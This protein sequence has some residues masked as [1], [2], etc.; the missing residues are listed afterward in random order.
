MKKAKPRLKKKN[1][2][3]KSF[4]IVAIGASAGGL[5]AISELLENLSPETGMAF[6]YIQ[7]LDPT[8]K[9]MLSTI[10][11]RFTKMKVLEA[12]H[13]MVLERNHVYIIP[14]NK[15]MAVS[16]GMLTLDARQAKPAAHMPID[17]FFA[18][19]AENRKEEAIGIVLSGNASDG[20]LGLNAIKKAGGLTFAQDETAKFQSMPRSA[21]AEGVIDLVLSPKEIGDELTRISQHTDAI[22]KI[23]KDATDDTALDKDLQTIIQLLKESTGVDFRHYKKNT[24]RRRVVRRM[25]LHKLRVLK[26]YV[27]YLK[28]NPQEIKV[29]YQDLLINI[30]SFFRDP[31]TLEYLRKSLL[32]K[33]I[34]GKVPDEPVRIWVAAC[35]TGEEAYSLAII[36]M[37]IMEDRLPVIP[38]QIFATDLSQQAIAK[39]RLGTYSKGDVEGISPDRLKRF[40]LKTENGYRIAKAI[41]D[42]CVFAPHNVLK[43]PPFSRL[44]LI[45]C[46]NLM[47]YLNTALQK[48]ILATFHY[49]LNPGGYLVLGKSETIGTSAQLFSAVE[50]KYKVFARKK[51]TGTRV[52]NELT[53]RLSE[54]ELP[55]RKVKR[56][57]QREAS[58]PEGGLERTVEEVLLNNYVPASV[59]VNQDM[60][61]LHFR[62]STGLFLEPAS[63]KASFNLLKMARA[64]LAFE[65]RSAVH[66][67]NKS[68]R[69]ERKAG[70]EIKGKGVSHLASIEVVPLKSEGDEKLFLV[71]ME[72]VPLPALAKGKTLLSKDK[73]VLQLQRELEATKED[74]RS[75]LEEQEASVEELQSANEEIVSSNEELQSINEELET[76]KEEVEST[77]EELMTINNELQVKNEQL[78][79]SYEYA[80]A[81]FDT[82]REA[83]LI[84][85]KDFRIKSAN[86]A[87][88][89]I[90]H[91][92]EEETEG[93]LIYELG[94]RQWD[95]LRLRQLLE[96]VI[97]HNAQFTGFEVSREFERIGEKIMRLSGRRIIQKTHRQL[98][99]LAIEDITEQ[100]Q[101]Q[102]LIAERELWFRTMAD[103]APVMIWVTGQ[104][105]N[106]NFFN[107]TWLEYTGRKPGKDYGHSWKESIHPDDLPGYLNIFEKKF[108]LREPFTAE[109]RMKRHDGEYRWIQESAKPNFLPGE[110]FSGY[111]GSC[112]EIHDK[113]IVHEELEK[114]V[115]QR[116]RDLQ[117]INRELER[118]NSELQQ[119]AYVASHDLQEP[120]RKI[121]TFA[122]RI[123]RFKDL[124]PELGATYIDK[125]AESSMRMTR[126]IDELLKFSRISR[127]D[128]AFEKTDLNAILNN[129]LIDFDL[130]ITE[131]KV[132]ID[133]Q[134][135][136]VIEAIPVQMKQ[137]FHNLVSNAIK[138]TREKTEPV[139][140]ISC[141]ILTEAETKELSSLRRA[142]PYVEIVFTD[143][144]IGFSPEFS[145]QIF[146]IFQQLNDKYRY[147]GT[148]IGLALCRKIVTTH[149]GRI[150]AVS[151]ENE[152][153]A[154]HVLLPVKQ[155][156]DN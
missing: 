104:S 73:I 144:G 69:A 17:N 93:L 72:E 8:H 100:R 101:A 94:N 106:R 96:E 52:K 37:E 141:R 153:S 155:S 40:F 108:T 92:S 6:V 139:I 49:A 137:L 87:F 4:P 124:L 71:I 42:L 110:V 119:F 18:I 86:K 13:Q 36:L 45:S 129:V 22:H 127:A 7:H 95:I 11:A 113:K 15:N 25:L 98:I 142:V 126:L 66:K 57:P 43:D 70:I 35:S 26:D 136:P 85:D 77:N 51:S 145:E 33:I 62:G 9:S 79:E 109:Y 27:R 146:I 5:E 28:G 143:N 67:A 78:S 131:K 147:P 55:R 58:V 112:T 122:D 54:T 133:K 140:S 82:I 99:L 150:Y 121:M 34:K 74:M 134:N 14:P 135:L 91:V 115:Q 20:T 19:L 114:R 118:S 148:G 103:N 83:V 32:P 12:K 44:D 75:I 120:L 65:L 130:L 38:V 30:T 16:D 111:I 102:R 80:E 88:Y 151:K 41:R 10:L 68:G 81:I 156:P 50:K 60:E 21:I 3:S 107:H 39:A 132:K 105:K 116:T 64:G 59:V 117:E 123:Q 53:S 23:L 46:C 149:G 90:F 29:L 31:D 84:L 154:F 56:P 152:G 89:E 48:K 76:S 97:P 125:I 63:G 138:F 61:I 24:I 128:A 2:R 47:I 1:P